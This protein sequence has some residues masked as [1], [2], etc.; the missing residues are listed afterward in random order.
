MICLGLDNRAKL[1]RIERYRRE[2]DIES[3][4]VLSPERFAF[5]VPNAD[6]LEYADII[7]YR[8]F[9]RLLQEIGP[10]SLV[11][12]NECLR[13]QSRYDLT[14]N[15]IRNFLNQ[16]SHQIVFQ[17][18]PLI[19]TPEDFAILFDFDT[20]SRW[21]RERFD[22]LPLAEAQIEVEPATIT[23]AAVEISAPAALRDAYATRKRSLI[24]GVGLKDPHTIPRNLYLLGGKRRLDL[25]S[26]DRKYV[27]R[28]NRFGLPN[29][30]T[31]R[32]VDDADER[33]VFE[34]PHNFI[35]FADFVAVTRQE[36]FEVLSTDLKVDR[37]Y[38]E[39]YAGW[40]SRIRNAYAA[41]HG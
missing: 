3:V 28:N 15:C 35:D 4:F 20:R 25:V 10:R 1:E 11:V 18:L 32:T 19:D 8:H 14:Y 9:Y 21:K 27:G 33:T 40:A 39:R 29:L 6:H 41:I 17:H 30:I 23:F 7:M 26:P 24:D 2:H 16:T 38:L 31:Y 37:W 5:E 36:R 34:L 13:T 22:R 12:V